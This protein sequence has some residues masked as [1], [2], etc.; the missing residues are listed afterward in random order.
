M[1]LNSVDNVIVVIGTLATL[2]YFFFTYK[3][4][5]VLHASSEIG[6]WVIMVTFGAAFGSGIMGRLSL[7]ID[8]ILLVFRDWLPLIQSSVG[9]PW[10]ERVVRGGQTAADP[11]LSPQGMEQIP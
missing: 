9:A 1:T 8:R 4:N 7:L 11:P 5:P 3:Q 2:S 10:M 6:K